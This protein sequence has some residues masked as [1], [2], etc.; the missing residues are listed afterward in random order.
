MPIAP[1]RDLKFLS[2]KKLF[3]FLHFA[4]LINI[5]FVSC[6]A[7]VQSHNTTPIVAKEAPEYLSLRPKL[8]KEYGYT[9]AVK[10]GND[11]KI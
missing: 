5:L 3:F 10:I 1:H 6:K 8:E 7:K 2:M 11:L 4:F 9:H